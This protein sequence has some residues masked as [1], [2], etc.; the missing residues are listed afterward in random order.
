MGAKKNKK[1]ERTKKLKH[2]HCQE[3][4]AIRQ[5]DLLRPL[6][7]QSKE[8]SVLRRIVLRRSTIPPNGPEREDVEGKHETATKQR[9][10]SR[11]VIRRHRLTSPKDPPSLFS[12]VRCCLMVMSPSGCDLILRTDGLSSGSTRGS[13][14]GKWVS[15]R[16]VFET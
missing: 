12:E 3:P 9:R 4:L 14:R 1:A 10:A 5:R 7:Q 13:A 2:E 6:F 8:Q 16:N 15:E 11:R